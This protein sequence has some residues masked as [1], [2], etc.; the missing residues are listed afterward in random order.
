VG[1]FEN[2]VPDLLHRVQFYF[3]G[4]RER[5]AWPWVALCGWGY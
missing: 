3:G 5:F 2:V 4:T 1:D